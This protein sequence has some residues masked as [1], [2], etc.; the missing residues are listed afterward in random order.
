MF[1]RWINVDE[2]FIELLNFSVHRIILF[3]YVLH[4]PECIHY[5][6]CCGL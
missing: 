1:R 5:I 4:L 3:G 2:I 6:G